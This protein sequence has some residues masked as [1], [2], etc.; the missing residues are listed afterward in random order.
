MGAKEVVRRI[1]RH[2]GSM[3]IISGRRAPL[4]GG[5][6]SKNL[7]GV[8]RSLQAS[9]L[10]EY[11][12]RFRGPLSSWRITSGLSLVS[13]LVPPPLG[14]PLSL[15]RWNL[16][17]AFFLLI[18]VPSCYSLARMMRNGRTAPLHGG[19]TPKKSGSIWA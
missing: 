9:R 6:T 11:L 3:I 16:I 12:L 8:Q 18:S 19:P 10:G 14:Q 13:I 2:A 1:M 5:P 7:R 4:L 17:V 15:V